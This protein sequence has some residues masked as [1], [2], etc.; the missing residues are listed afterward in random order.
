M[1]WD[2]GLPER[3]THRQPNSEPVPQVRVVPS[4]CESLRSIPV[5]ETGLSQTLFPSKAL[6]FTLDYVPCLF[7]ILRRA[8]SLI[9]PGSMLE[10]EAVPPHLADIF[11]CFSPL[12]NRHRPIPRCLQVWPL[13]GT[14]HPARSVCRIPAGLLGRGQTGSL[15]WSF[16]LPCPLLCHLQLSFLLFS[17]RGRCCVLSTFRVLLSPL[18][19]GVSPALPGSWEPACLCT[20]QA[21]H[22]HPPGPGL[23]R[24]P[25]CR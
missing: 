4:R 9:C 3:K 10:V 21:M 7:F 16:S 19:L 5:T 17:Q 2:P 8:K 24:D 20:H 23:L 6:A 15:V 11:C 12:K 13:E 25:A 1:A 18:Q 14:N 22:A